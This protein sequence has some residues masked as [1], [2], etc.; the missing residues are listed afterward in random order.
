VT[1]AS[2]ESSVKAI[3]KFNEKGLG[4]LQVIDENNKLVGMITKG[5]TTRGILVTLQR[6][7]EEEE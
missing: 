2:Y 6:D 4:R 5:D 7:Y 1:V 3:R